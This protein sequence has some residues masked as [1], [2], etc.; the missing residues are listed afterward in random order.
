MAPELINNQT[1]P[2]T[3]SFLHILAVK[4]LAPQIAGKLQLV[5]ARQD[6]Y[7]NNISHNLGGL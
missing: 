1:V 6:K 7:M 5:V 3:I 4:E 2:T